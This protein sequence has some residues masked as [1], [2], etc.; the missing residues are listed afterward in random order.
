[1]SASNNAGTL[2]TAVSLSTLVISGVAR[3]EEIDVA[4]SLLA[5]VSSSIIVGLLLPMP[6][7]DKNL[8][9][10]LLVG[11]VVVVVVVLSEEDEELVEPE[12]GDEDVV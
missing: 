11:D 4:E 5:K 9:N 3:V 6:K 12:E 8:L 2:G 7:N 1:M 10:K